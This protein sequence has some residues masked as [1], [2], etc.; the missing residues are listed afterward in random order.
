MKLFT[1]PANQCRTV[2][3]TAR[4]AGERGC[5]KA[6]FTNCPESAQAWRTMWEADGYIVEPDLSPEPVARPF[7]RG[8]SSNAHYTHPDGLGSAVLL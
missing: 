3:Y 1:P 7:N 6:R 4:R 5:H 8:G 2:A